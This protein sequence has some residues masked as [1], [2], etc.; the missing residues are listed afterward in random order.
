M[1][2]TSYVLYFASLL[3]ST[4]PYIQLVGEKWDNEGR[5]KLTN[6]F[7]TR[8]TQGI[9][10]AQNGLMVDNFVSSGGNTML[11]RTETLTSPGPDPSSRLH[12]ASLFLGK[13]IKLDFLS[14][15]NPDFEKPWI[16]L[17][18]NTNTH[19]DLGTD[20]YTDIHTQTHIDTETER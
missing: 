16:G 8:R 10:S 19:I 3:I 12:L 18:L 9:F 2:C 4:G 17:A 6:Q 5:R 11:P 15:I 13:D 14:S 7:C 20:K 1:F